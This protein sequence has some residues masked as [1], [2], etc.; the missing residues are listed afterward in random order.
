MGA[1][2]RNSFSSSSCRF[3]FSSSFIRLFASF[4]CCA[5][6]RD[7]SGVRVPAPVS[8]SPAL[9]LLT[10][11][12]IV[13]L[14]MPSSSAAA[15]CKLHR[16]FF[17]FLTVLFSC[18]HSEHNLSSFIIFRFCWL[19]QV[20]LYYITSL[21]QLEREQLKLRQCIYRSPSHS[22]TDILPHLVADCPRH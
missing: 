3:F 10:H 7:S 8:I 19:C 6:L 1:S 11:V 20:L 22:C 17:V 9:A 21:S 16:F 15:F 2:P 4:S 13:P 12:P 18:S 14:G 5:R